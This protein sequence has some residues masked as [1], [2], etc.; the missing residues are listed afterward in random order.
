MKKECKQPKCGTCRHYT[1]GRYEVPVCYVK[2][3]DYQSDILKDY[4]SDIIKPCAIAIKPT[5][6]ACSFYIDYSYTPP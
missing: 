5:N 1:V 4:W 2:F 6:T 3:K